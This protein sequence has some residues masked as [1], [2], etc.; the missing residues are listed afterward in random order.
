MAVALFCWERLFRPPRFALAG[1]SSIGAVATA[2][3]RCALRRRKRLS[4]A[5]SSVAS[6]SAPGH[7]GERD[8]VGGKRGR[9][10]DAGALP[11]FIESCLGR[12]GNTK[13]F[14]SRR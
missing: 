5:C 11:V 4:L 6:V 3:T 13:R 2:A 12:T 7:L 1:F 10:H 8:L 9:R 14:D